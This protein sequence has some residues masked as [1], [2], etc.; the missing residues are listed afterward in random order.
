MSNLDPQATPFI[1][2]YGR[3][4]IPMS[5]SP[6]VPPYGAPPAQPIQPEAIGK[7]STLNPQAP[8]FVPGNA[9]VGFR[10]GSTTSYTHSRVQLPSHAFPRQA[11]VPAES[12]PSTAPVETRVRVE[13][14]VE[15]KAEPKAAVETKTSETSPVEAPTASSWAAMV[16]KAAAA[17]P[18]QPAES[19]A[20]TTVS[21]ASP[22]V[23]APKPKAVAVAKKK[24]SA[25]T[26]A[27][28]KPKREGAKKAEGVKET[29]PAE[30]KSTEPKTLEPK[31][32]ESKAAEPKTAGPKAVEA[33]AQEPKAVEAKAAEPKAVEPKA[34][35][36]QQKTEAP[37]TPASATPETNKLPSARSWAKIVSSPPPIVEKEV[38]SPT[39]KRAEKSE[40]TKETA[41][42]R[43]KQEAT[44]AVKSTKSEVLKGSAS[45]TVAPKVKAS[46]PK[47]KAHR[48]ASAEKESETP[49]IG[50]A[51]APTREAK[52]AEGVAAAGKTDDAPE[53]DTAAKAEMLSPTPSV[54]APVA[55]KP[56]ET[57]IPETKAVNTKPVEPKA[58]EI[59]SV[60]PKLAETQPA[61]TK[62]APEAP[63][64]V[65]AETSK[66]NTTSEAS[67]ADSVPATPEAQFSL[68][69]TD[70]SRVGGLFGRLAERS[71]L[72]RPSAS[73]R[74]NAM[75]GNTD[76]DDVIGYRPMARGPLGLKLKDKLH[77]VVADI[78]TYG[79]DKLDADSK[80]SEVPPPAQP[81]FAPVARLDTLVT[82][83]PTYSS[84]A[85]PPVAASQPTFTYSLSSN[86]VKVYQIEDMLSIRNNPE[87]F[88]VGP[89]PASPAALFRMRGAMSN[90]AGS[91]MFDIPTALGHGG[92]GKGLDRM[93]EEGSNSNWNLRAKDN[94]PFRNAND[95]LSWIRKPAT[96]VPE[97]PKDSWQVKQ[98]ESK[99]AAS[100]DR[101]IK[102][103]RRLRAQLNKMT[104]A[105]Y[106]DIYKA[107]WN[108]GISNTEDAQILVNL[109]FEKAITNHQYIDIYARVCGDL[110]KDLETE[111]V[112]EPGSDFKHLLAGCCQ[113]AFENYMA[114]PFE[115]PEGIEEDEEFELLLLHKK[116]MKGN[117]VFV[118]ALVMHGVLTVRVLVSILTR[119]I[120]NKDS[121]QLE[122]L[123]AFLPT[124]GNSLEAS[125][126]RATFE[127][128][129]DKIRALTKDPSVELR[130]RCLLLDCVEQQDQ[131]AAD[132]ARQ[133][134]KTNSQ[135]QSHPGMRPG[136][137]KTRTY[138]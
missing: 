14:K 91:A 34:A 25:K 3:L 100:A 37:T 73:S 69:Q 85:P 110:K 55:H 7:R 137:P 24:A 108:I 119:L 98:A 56:V 86:N 136:L 33:K 38:S 22:K 15:T 135:L 88:K 99:A 54:E 84:P 96:E 132:Q 61:E 45:E 112:L 62:T 50:R 4:P 12:A 129:M 48:A 57:K 121:L 31:A 78:G 82:T 105:T 92:K 51:E 20:T 113:T 18:E 19:G 71:M 16:K 83:E 95:N 10:P 118:S 123:A 27:A 79:L 107:I 80:K 120:D 9:S 53:V 89:K 72:S 32:V 126:H 130:I 29:K 111:G 60:E 1:P 103:T 11:P 17:K 109:V 70:S 133:F 77:C 101:S 13:P 35:E 116:K 8:A 63:K 36:G 68:Q 59:R 5:G 58:A 28:A 138:Q 124:V 67:K 41:K 44:K 104:P 6:G 21:A 75:L 39:E 81:L 66:V 52:A 114:K 2:T 93:L 134:R 26:R 97:V 117:L 115:A 49:T 90:A 46:A 74:V 87:C 102:L 42:P 128:M 65:V 127:N 131:A 23:A 40:A 43:V 76:D 94:A 47:Q 125:K 122:A 64:A 30:P 106:E